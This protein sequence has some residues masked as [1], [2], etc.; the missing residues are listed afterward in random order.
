MLTYVHDVVLP[1]MLWVPVRV[2]LDSDRGR[3]YV[4]RLAVILTFG[5]LTFN[6][7]GTSGVMSPNSVQNLSEIEQ[8]TAE[9]LIN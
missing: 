4:V 2:H 5:P 1:M 3:L 8:S 9:L 7:Y 6:F